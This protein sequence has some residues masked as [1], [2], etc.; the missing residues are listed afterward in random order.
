MGALAHEGANRWD[1][2]TAVGLTRRE[3][4]GVMPEALKTLL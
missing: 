4:K 3:S 1:L 2:S